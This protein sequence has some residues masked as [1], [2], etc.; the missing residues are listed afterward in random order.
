VT[1][2]IPAVA[3]RDLSPLLPEGALALGLCLVLLAD[4][5]PALRARGAAVWIGALAAAAGAWLAWSQPAGTGA[6]AQPGMLEFDP[7]AAI[8]RPALALLTAVVLVA[9][10]GERRRAA[11]HGAWTTCVLGIGLGA[12]LVAAAA[13][14]LA[15]WLGLELVSLGSYALAAWRGGDRKAAEAGMKYVL[16][17]GAASG[18]MLYG[19]SHL[20]GLT[21]HFDFAGI[22][23][24]FAHGMPLRVLGALLLASVG[25]AYKLT[26]VPFH[27]YAPD[28][29]QGA[30]ALSVAAVAAVPKLAAGAVLVRALAVL[31]PPTL[32]PPGQVA[33]VL[34]VAAILSL[35]VASFT[36][37]AQRDAKRIVAFSG[38]GHGG[39]VVLAAA[40]Q[41]EGGRG[42]AA[43][44]LFYLL[45]YAAS[46]LG[47]LLVLSV[48]ERECGSTGLGA[49]A[50]AARRR[51]WLGAALV[52]FLFS[53]AGVPPLAGFTA[54][55]AVL[56]LALHG[57]PVLVVG[58][59][60]LLAST[61]VFAWAY[62][63]IVR[64]AVLAPAPDAEP[65]AKEPLPLPT[66]LVLLLCA[67]A[68]VGLGLWLDGPQAVAKVLTP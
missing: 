58:A 6:G 68:T 10:A 15:L 29:Y 19:M 54:K 61:A 27:F 30:P 32:V 60:A 52:L 17:G 26:I 43:A 41:P 47:A 23:A 59:L 21:G 38:I 45:A 51:P 22:G 28:V 7:I 48:L 31:V 9:A 18:L 35:G 50:G 44:A 2:G 8:A 66:L 5:L 55:W 13:N 40:C 46:N 14:V 16:F 64:A 3:A 25:V 24:A 34:A 39:T 11:D 53:L 1:A 42:A 67:L 37:L 62:L 65:P 20:Y 57:P 63:L 12:M 4:L 56:Q 49:L 33:A 36:S